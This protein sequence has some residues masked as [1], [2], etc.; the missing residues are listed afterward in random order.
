M[1]PTLLGVI[2]NVLLV[3]L[4]V[5][6][7]IPSP[8]IPCG[9][10]GALMA[11]GHRK[12]EPYVSKWGTYTFPG[13]NE[14]PLNHWEWAFSFSRPSSLNTLLS[15]PLWNGAD[16]LWEQGESWGKALWKACYWFGP[17]IVYSREKYTRSSSFDCWWLYLRSLFC[18][19]TLWF[20]VTM[21]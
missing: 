8:T 10:G 14:E 21:A 7:L 11:A 12:W 6:A 9:L 19:L 13:G 5:T 1:A 4:P 18:H 2:V 16:F 20:S 15:F 3:H 17:V